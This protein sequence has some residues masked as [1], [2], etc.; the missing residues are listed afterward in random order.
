[1]LLQIQQ[2]YPVVIVDKSNY[3]HLIV[4]KEEN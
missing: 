2:L 1:M 3:D 4:Y